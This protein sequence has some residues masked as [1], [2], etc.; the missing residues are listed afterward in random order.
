MDQCYL[1]VKTVTFLVV[2]PKGPVGSPVS[3]PKRLNQTWRLN[4]PLPLV[5]L[6]PKVSTK[7]QS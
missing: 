3:F 4:P 1:H 6:I 7:R 2:G 5:E